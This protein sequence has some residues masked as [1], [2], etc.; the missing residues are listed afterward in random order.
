MPSS[1]RPGLAWRRCAPAL[2]WRH[3]AGSGAVFDPVTGETHFLSDLPAMLVT[4]IDETWCDTRTLIERIAGSIQLDAGEHAKVLA[5]LH[6]LEGAEL[7][8]S[9]H[10]KDA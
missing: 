7:V 3:E 10:E 8:E 2:E 6:Y 9:R 5:A 1:D 4:E